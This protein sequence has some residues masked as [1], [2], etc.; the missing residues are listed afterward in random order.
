VF[1]EAFPDPDRLSPSTLRELAEPNG[2]AFE[3]C[4][5]TARRDIV[6]LRRLSSPNKAWIVL[7]IS[8]RWL[9]NGATIG[10]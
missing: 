9:R 6:R 8:R 3:S 2:F 10:S 4:D 5:G 7:S 1:V